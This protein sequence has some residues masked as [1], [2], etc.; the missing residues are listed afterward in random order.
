E[1]VI[2]LK[3]HF[4]PEQHEFIRGMTYIREAAVTDRLEEVDPAWS[5]DIQRIDT[6]GEQCVVTVRLT[7]KGVARD[8]VGMS[9]VSYTRDGETE[10]NEPEKAAAT[11]ALK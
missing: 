10:A 8:G 6:R 9:K 4:T 3:A 7:V 5:L 2:T 11:D 1:D